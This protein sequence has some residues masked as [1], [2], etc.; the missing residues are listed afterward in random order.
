MAKLSRKGVFNFSIR[1][2]ML[3]NRKYD[4]LLD[5]ITKKGYIN[6]DTKKRWSERVDLGEEI[7]FDATD[8]DYATPNVITSHTNSKERIDRPSKAMNISLGNV[9]ENFIYRALL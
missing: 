8:R 3:P 2:S 4:N 7:L 9:G 6:L 5:N 1:N